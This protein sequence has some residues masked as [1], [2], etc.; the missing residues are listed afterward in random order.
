M[1]KM[2]FLKLGGPLD[3]SSNEFILQWENEA[4]VI[5]IHPV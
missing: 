1:S 5:V 3:I 4:R 2:R